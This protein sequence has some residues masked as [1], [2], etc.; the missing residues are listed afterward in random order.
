M[1]AKEYYRFLLQRYYEGSATAAEE[2]ELY[3]ELKK[4]A[5]DEAWVAL[6]DELHAGTVADPQY[7]PVEYEPMLQ[8]IL[9]AGEGPKVRRIAGWRR[10]AAAAAVLLFSVGGYYW[11]QHGQRNVL[12]DAPVAVAADVLPGK[13]GAVLTL[14]NGQQVVLDNH[15][16]GLITSTQGT[17]VVLKN[18]HVE[19]K[20]SGTG[21]PVNNTLHTPRGRKFRMQ[22]PDGTQVWLNAASSLSFPTAFT[23]KERKVELTGEAYFEVA[24]DQT[25][26]FVVS[27]SNNTSVKVLGTH[28]DI[29]AYTD[30]PGISTTLLEG[31]VQVNVP[32]HSSTLK[33]GQQLLFNK[34]AGT[35]V[36]NK[37]IDTAAV[38]AWKNGVLSF[39]D[40][41]LTAVIAMIARWYDIEVIYATTPP[42]ITFVG[43]IGSDVNLSS[44]LTFLRES[45]IQFNL[46]GRKLIIGKQ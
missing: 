24:K 6:M 46:E 16:D 27:L 41:K 28:F 2:E 38:M 20:S 36:L 10:W 4:H 19:Y 42:D 13:N 39:Q 29:S 37:N 9:Q 14:A 22:L 25:K 33:P 40:K 32:E 15:G 45:G 43:E 23:G 8:G 26:P 21:T 31:A 44:V 34:N 17:Q 35:V 18:G 7:N 5:D 30:E 11:W 12:S 1:E 3:A